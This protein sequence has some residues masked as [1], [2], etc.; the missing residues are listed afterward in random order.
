MDNKI[1]NAEKILRE[2]GV[3]EDAIGVFLT[4]VKYNKSQ[5][6]DWFELGIEDIYKIWQILD[7][8]EAE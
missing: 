5:P 1:S 7:D 2:N 6:L 8:I 4:S 3:S